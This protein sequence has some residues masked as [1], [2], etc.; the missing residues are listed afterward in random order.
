MHSYV[1]IFYGRKAL[2]Y[3]ERL[4]YGRMYK[5]TE[6]PLG[7]LLVGRNEGAAVYSVESFYV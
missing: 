1:L 7:F 2:L 5:P 6:S 4:P 3:I